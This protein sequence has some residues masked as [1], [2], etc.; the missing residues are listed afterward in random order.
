MKDAL[1][2][3][4]QWARNHL[5]F[6]ALEMY[7]GRHIGLLPTAMHNPA[8]GITLTTD[9]AASVEGMPAGRGAQSLM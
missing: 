9:F 8:D 6:N 3:V 1:H 2:K 7:T 5:I 4:G